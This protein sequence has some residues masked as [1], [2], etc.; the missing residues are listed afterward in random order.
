M[1][2]LH[3]IMPKKH[4]DYRYFTEN[5]RW[6]PKVKKIANSKNDKNTGKTGMDKRQNSQYHKTIRWSETQRTTKM[7]NVFL[8]QSAC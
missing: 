4:G 3:K 2:E 8:L 5:L 1:N 7:I 6:S